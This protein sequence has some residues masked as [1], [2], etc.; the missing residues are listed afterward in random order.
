[1]KRRRAKLQQPAPWRPPSPSGFLPDPKK[2]EA[3]VI[4]QHADGTRELVGEWPELT[5]LALGLLT[6]AGGV[7]RFDGERMVVTVNSRQQQ[8]Y[9]LLYRTEQTATFQRE[10]VY[11]AYYG[12]AQQAPAS[13]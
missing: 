11:A 2:A 6:D 3:I 5:E 1:M 4:R 12:L 13:P 8:A 7:F 10:D 9:R